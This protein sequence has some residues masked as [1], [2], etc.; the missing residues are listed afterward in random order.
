MVCCPP[1]T[2]FPLSSFAHPFALRFL[3][4]RDET[5]HNSGVAPARSSTIQNSNTE[6]DARQS[7]NPVEDDAYGGTA[8][9]G[10]GGGQQQQQQGHGR[11]RSFGGGG[12]NGDGMV[13]F[14]VLLLF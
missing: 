10:A 1:H 4:Q 11:D 5:S 14:R 7:R 13:S 12:P 3:P 6:W 9:W 8:G 2:L